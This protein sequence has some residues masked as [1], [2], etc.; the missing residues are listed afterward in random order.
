[1]LSLDQILSIYYEQMG[2]DIDTGKPL[3]DTLKKLGLEFAV[4]D[5]YKPSQKNLLA[6]SLCWMLNL[7]P[8]NT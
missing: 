3:P 8:R 7:N 5:I 4:K 1:M 2:W 6:Q